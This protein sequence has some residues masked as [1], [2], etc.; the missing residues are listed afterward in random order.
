[1]FAGALIVVVAGVVV[2]SRI[3]ADGDVIAQLEASGNCEYDTVVDG[4]PPA[5][6]DPG[7]T[8]AAEPGFYRIGD[9]TPSAD[10][11]VKAMRRGFVVLWYRTEAR[12]AEVDVATSLSDRF[13][14]DLIVVP[15]SPLTHP[16]I[17]TAWERRLRCTSPDEDAIARFTEAFRDAG[18]EKGF[19]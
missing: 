10:A 4:D 9:E 6:G 14:R 12:Q 8:E 19:L 5:G 1:M 3:G 7:E 15:K 17:V 13:G 2:Y 18:P 16:M 11:L